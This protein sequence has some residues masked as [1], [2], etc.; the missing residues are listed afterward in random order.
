MSLLDK[1]KLLV[2]VK[3]P[4]I[5]LISQIGGVGRGYKTFTFW[6][7]VVGSL[8]ALVGVLTGF[9]PGI[10]GLCIT[11]GLT[12]I[13]NI[14]R[15]L[16]KADQEGIRPVLK[17][18]EFWVGFLNSIGNGIMA[19]Q[20]GGINAEWLTAAQSIIAAAIGMAQNLASHQPDFVIPPYQ[21]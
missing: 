16:E 17:S 21:G 11:T 19:L 10:V 6:F 5:Q 9:L 15:G 13:Y 12:V 1:I 8:L 18:T 20:T 14:L 4:A 2:K 7:T 3:D